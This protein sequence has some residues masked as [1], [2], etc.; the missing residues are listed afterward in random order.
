M[1]TYL[2]RR[3]ATSIVILIGISILVF[4]LLHVIG[5][6]PGRDVLGL[7]G[8]AGRRSAPGTSSTASTGPLVVQY[9][10]YMANL[11]HGNLG[12]VLQAQ[13]VGRRAA[14]RARADLAPT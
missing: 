13:P 14:R 4:W 8:L 1:T 7:R 5:A 10:N 3:A 11:L 12:H 2:L 6:S 9:L